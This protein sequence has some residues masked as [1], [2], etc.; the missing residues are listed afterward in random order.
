MPSPSTPDRRRRR[1]DDRGVTLVELLVV[2][3]IMGVFGLLAFASVTSVTD[4]AVK[5][6]TRSTSI[7][8]AR[9]ALEIIIRDLRAANPIEYRATVAEY[10]TQISFEVY[11]EVDGAIVCPA[12]NLRLVEYALDGNT[13][14]RT[15]DGSAGVVLSPVSSS[16]AAASRLAVV[17]TASQPLF[18]YFDRDGDRIMTTGPTAA[19]GTKFRDCTKTV[20][21]DLRVLDRTRGEERP[22]R[23]TTDVAIRNYNEVSNC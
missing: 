4:T 23:I 12:D 22:F 17:N 14:R 18:Q 7:D 16:L 13:L 20:R 21:V 11:C 10:D 5:T 8:E 2:M 15:V 9:R 19:D 1:G 6:Q 3:S